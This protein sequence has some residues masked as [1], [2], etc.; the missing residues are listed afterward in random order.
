MKLLGRM[1]EKQFKEYSNQSPAKMDETVRKWFGVP[2]DK[3][4]SVS[5]WPEKV[6]GNVWLD[7]RRHRTVQTEKISKSNQ[8]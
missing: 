3:Y 1:T 7:Q 5:V 6:A 8:Q 4:Y 2:K